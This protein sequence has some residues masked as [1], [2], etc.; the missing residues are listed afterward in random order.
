M[1]DLFSLLA[2]GWNNLPSIWL[3]IVSLSHFSNQNIPNALT[4]SITGGDKTYPIYP[5]KRRI[6]DFRVG[7]HWVGDFRVGDI[8]LIHETRWFRP[9]VIMSLGDFQVG[10]FVFLPW[11]GW[12]CL[13]GDFATFATS[14]CPWGWG[15]QRKERGGEKRTLQFSCCP[16]SLAIDLLRTT[17]NVHLYL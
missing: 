17:S 4:L 7:D 2:T 3:D 14:P 12:F 13:L 10:D 11:S 6:R 16:S 15:M 8:V 1:G 9:W 5:Y